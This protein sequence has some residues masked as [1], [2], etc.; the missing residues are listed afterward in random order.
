MS[1]DRRRFLTLAAITGIAA[2]ADLANLESVEAAKS[3]EDKVVDA[4]KRYEGSSDYCYTSNGKLVLLCLKLCGD[5]YQAA[6]YPFKRYGSAAIAYDK[7]K[8][9][10][11][12]TSKKG[13]LMFWG[14][15]L[16]PDGH[17]AIYLGDNKVLT[18]YT[19]NGGWVSSSS[20]K[21]AIVNHDT[22]KSKLTDFKGYLHIGDAITFQ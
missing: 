17:V 22:I 2:F 8:K 5:V 10:V 13:C 6:G 1:L 21:V 4:A 12:N 18:S 14:T 15:R 9:K 11:Q 16:G 19:W 7:M 3:K 20:K